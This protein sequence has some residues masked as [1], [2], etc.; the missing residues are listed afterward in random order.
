M[1]KCGRAGQAKDDNIIRRM[2][3]ACWLPKATNTYS[4][5]GILIACS[6]L[7]WLQER[8]LM[9][10]YTYI[11]CL[12]LCTTYCV[13]ESSKNTHILCTFCI[14]LNIIVLFTTYIRQI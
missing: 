4:E 12:V 8:A 14:Y 13:L 5:Y 10:S 7:Q 9:L 1:E 6:L 3:F 2:R 11:A